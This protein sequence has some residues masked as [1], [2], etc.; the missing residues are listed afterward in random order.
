M[1][2]TLRHAIKSDMSNNDNIVEASS[3]F[4][5]PARRRFQGIQAQLMNFS[6]HPAHE[7]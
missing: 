3:K 5:Q 7:T 2:E 4:T 1:S 6:L